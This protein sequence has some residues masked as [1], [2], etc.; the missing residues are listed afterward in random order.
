MSTYFYKFTLNNNNYII[1]KIQLIGSISYSC[2]EENIEGKYDLRKFNIEGRW[3]WVPPGGLIKEWL[4]LYSYTI[5][6]V[7]N[8]DD[9]IKEIHNIIGNYDKIETIPYQ[10]VETMLLKVI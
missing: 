9:N 10:L 8:F 1:F 3:K 2:L 4:L 5:F 6:N 7:L